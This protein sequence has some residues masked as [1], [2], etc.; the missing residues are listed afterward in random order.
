MKELI[1][2]FPLTKLEQKKYVMPTNRDYEILSKVKQLEA[3]KLSKQDK[4]LALLIKTQLESNWR[5]Y[6][7][8]A[9]NKLLKKY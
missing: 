8:Q 1:K 3:L 4:S 2:R 7:V 6:L 9:L 5:K